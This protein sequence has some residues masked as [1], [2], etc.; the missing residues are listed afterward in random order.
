MR[1]AFAEEQSGI[2]LKNHGAALTRF[3]HGTVVAPTP[4][5]ERRPTLTTRYL[6]IAPGRAL[7]SMA[8]QVGGTGT[9]NG[10]WRLCR[11]G[12]SCR[13]FLLSRR[14]PLL[15]LCGVLFL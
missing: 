10:A 3:S 6:P 5:P 7:P 12:L 1:H 13:M 14:P 2:V 4:A 15:H 11:C 9:G 8:R